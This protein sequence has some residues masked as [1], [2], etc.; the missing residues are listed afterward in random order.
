M[1]RLRYEFEMAEGWVIWDNDNY[2][3][4]VASNPRLKDTGFS[5]SLNPV[6]I[7]RYRLSGISSR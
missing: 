3:G 7:S 6:R 4:F 5:I 2:N 1:L